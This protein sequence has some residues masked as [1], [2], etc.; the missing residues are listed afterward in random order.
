M[1]SGQWP[2]ASVQCLSQGNLGS[3]KRLVALMAAL[4]L[5]A[6]LA[7]GLLVQIAPLLLARTSL[8]F[9]VV[10][11]VVVHGYIIANRACTAKGKIG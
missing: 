10:I 4:A 1:A 3:S 11:V 7:L 9:V 8:I 5:V 6:V 2:V